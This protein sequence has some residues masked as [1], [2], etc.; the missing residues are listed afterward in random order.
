MYGAGED[1]VAAVLGVPKFQAREWL[2]AHR[3]VY[4]RYW[5]W[6]DAMLNHAALTGQMRTCFGWTL[7]V[8]AGFRGRSLRNFP[9]Q[10]HG[11]EMMRLAACI[12]TEQGVLVCAPV[13]D[14]FLIEADADAIDAETERMQAIMRKASEH[15]LPGFPLRTDAKIVR[16]PER[17]SDPRGAE[18]WDTVCR[19]ADEREAADSFDVSPYS[20]AQESERARVWVSGA[21]PLGVEGV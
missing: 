11:A 1:T 20:D 7:H 4:R 14:A 21:S 6:S 19:L 9:M 16:H 13:H 15:V 5:E 12:A 2:Y 3:V 8:E 10:A 17:Y 18:F